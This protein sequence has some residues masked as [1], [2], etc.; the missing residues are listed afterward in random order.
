MESR[1]GAACIRLCQ[2]AV[3]TM[4]KEKKTTC[5]KRPA[6]TMLLANLVTSWV[7]ACA[8]IP[9]PVGIEVSVESGEL[10]TT[11]KHTTRLYKEGQDIA[12]DE[13]LR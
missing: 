1:V 3:T 11:I 5:K 6:R 9:P 7:F 8:S 2:V 10:A 12:Y 13:D 4:K